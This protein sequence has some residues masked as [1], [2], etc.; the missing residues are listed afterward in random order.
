M[1]THANPPTRRRKALPE[2]CPDWLADALGRIEGQLRSLE[3]GRLDRLAFS[4][5]ESAQI[6]GLSRSS[7][8]IAI[9]D[10][11]LKTRKNGRRTIILREDLQ[12]FLA[13]LPDG[14]PKSVNGYLPRRITRDAD[15]GR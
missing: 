6:A 5:A 15:N 12:S 11:R 10:G 13:S 8:Y 3:I 9:A 2:T 4:I 14:M 7:L 1:E